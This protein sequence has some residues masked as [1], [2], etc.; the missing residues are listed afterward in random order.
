M[1]TALQ[2]IFACSRSSRAIWLISNCLVWRIRFE[3]RLSAGSRTTLESYC[4]RSIHTFPASYCCRRESTPE[5]RTTCRDRSDYTGDVPF[6]TVRSPC[7]WPGCR[8]PLDSNQVTRWSWLMKPYLL[9]MISCFG[10]SSTSS[11]RR[12]GREPACSRLSCCRPRWRD[13]GN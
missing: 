11:C 8:Y 5:E 10:R 9:T 3:R 7:G 6:R 13:F 12:S 2:R 1:S 4:S